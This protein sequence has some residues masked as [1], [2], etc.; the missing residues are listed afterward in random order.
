MRKQKRKASIGCFLLILLVVVGILIL[1]LGIPLMVENDF[2][3]ASTALTP[4]QVRQYGLRLLLAKDAFASPNPGLERS[5]PFEIQEGSSI[6]KIASDLQL[7]GLIKR[8]DRFR[9]YL[10]YKGIDSKIRSGTFMIPNT[11]VA[12]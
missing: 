10:I 9:D 6:S 12:S 1:W 11:L 5:I 4:F 7:A 3:S 8:G 2:G